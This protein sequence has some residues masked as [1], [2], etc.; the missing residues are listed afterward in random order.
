MKTITA[1]STG[2]ALAAA[3]GLFPISSQAAVVSQWSFEGNLNDTAPS[4]A[5]ADTLTPQGT[6]AYA[7]GVVGQAANVTF[8]GMQR[9]RA[10]TSADMHLGANW[11]L[12]AFVRPD[13]SNT[14]E[15]DRFWT[16]WGDGGNE[17]HL[18][19]RSTGTVIVDNGIDLFVN[20]SNNILNSNSTASVPLNIWSHVAIVGNQ[21]ANTITAWLNGKQVGTAAW[22]AVTPTAGAMN[23]G[24]FETPGAALQY[25]GLIDEATIHNTAATPAY[26]AGRAAL[27]PEPASLAFSS[28]AGL[29]LLLRRRR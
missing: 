26:L 4:G 27:I 18:T 1:L 8:S 21:S 23:F 7:T 10:L 20:A 5:S 25:S 28:L 22:V 17:W 12:E 3:A 14:G 15:W 29:T 11:T 2:L 13:S 16:V 24:N 19:F 9:I 6:A